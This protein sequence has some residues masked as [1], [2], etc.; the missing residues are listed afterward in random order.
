MA[1]IKN[2]KLAI[3]ERD[4]GKRNTYLLLVRLQTDTA[5]SKSSTRNTQ[6]VKNKYTTQLR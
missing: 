2:L 1:K 5:T 3:L 6:K 4:V